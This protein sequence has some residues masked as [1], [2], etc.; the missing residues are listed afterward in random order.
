MLKLATEEDFPEILRMARAFHEVSPYKDLPFDEDSCSH[1][2]NM[3]LRGDKSEIIIILAKDEYTY[4]MII[5]VA[6]T[7][8]FTSA[9][10]STEM[11]WWVDYDYRGSKDSLLLKKAYEDWAV[12]VGAKLTQMAML[13]EVAN[14]D[15][16]YR[17][18]GYRPAE[19][20]YIKET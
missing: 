12:R 16:F 20:S 19:R 6:N 1:I 18:Q 5:G 3:Y 11:A 7:L 14:L 9:K 8:P 10:V 15:K 13:D 2:F 4:G 17:R